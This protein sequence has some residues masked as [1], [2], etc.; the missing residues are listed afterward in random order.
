[1]KNIGR[2]CALGFLVVTMIT[3]CTREEFLNIQPRGQFVP[4]TVAD[5]RLFL[6]QTDTDLNTNA[7]SSGFEEKHQ[8]S[9]YINDNFFISEELINAEIGIGQSNI[10]AYRFEDFIFNA[11]D[12]DPDWNLYYNQIYLSNLVLEGLKEVTDGT[13]QEIAALVAEAKVHR[14]YAYFNLVNLYAEHYDPSSAETDLGVPIREGISL[15][16]V[17]LERAT[18]EVVYSFIIDDLQESLV[19]LPD[20]VDNLFSFRPSKAAAYGLLA[21]IFLFR[22]EYGSARSAAESALGINDVLRNLNNDGTSIFNN[23]ILRLPAVA[24]DPEVIWYKEFFGNYFVRPEFLSIYEENDLRRR[25]FGGIRTSLSVNVDG[26]FFAASRDNQLYIDGI[27]TPELYLISAECSARLGE[28]SSANLRLNQLRESRFITDGYIELNVQDAD[29]LLE[30]IKEERRRELIGGT[31]R[32][33][34]LKRYNKLDND[35]ITLTHQIGNQSFTLP[36][37]DV[38]WALPIAELYI[39]QNPEIVQNPRN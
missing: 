3:S 16:D 19:S 22:S 39:Q 27:N 31:H 38:K 5:F 35:N 1:M 4:N 37:N 6:D 23:Q 33:F 26:F 34:D 15:T 36:P 25:W 20:S 2:N 17:N 14:A 28:F 32:F 7:S 10:R 30:F 21:R 29:I 9:A 12:S 8:V 11:Q 13:P 24:N 18:V